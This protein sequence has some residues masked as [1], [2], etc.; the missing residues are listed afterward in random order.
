MEELKVIESLDELTEE[1]K[2]ELSDGRGNTNSVAHLVA[3]LRASAKTAVYASKTYS[4]LASMIVASPFY[5]APRFY[6]ISHIVVHHMSGNL[7]ARLCGR[8]FQNPSA[9]CSSNYGVGSDGT[10]AGYVPEEFR[11]WTTG[12]WQIDHKAITIEVA[13]DCSSPWHCSD[14]AYK[15]TVRL[16]ADICKRNGIKKLTFTGDKNGNLHWHRWYQNTDCPASWWMAKERSGEFTRD[17]ND[18]LNGKAKYTGKLPSKIP[19]RG[20]YRIG[21][22]YETYKGYTGQIKRIQAFLN[23]RGESLAVDG[24][25]GEKTNKAVLRFQKAEGMKGTHGNW[26]KGT[27]EKAEKYC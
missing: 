4:P 26:G 20:Y 15:A 12:N 27:Q 2:L 6:K 11:A 22:G 19:K 21:D 24:F 8:W 13:D 18:I 3:S 7:S 5:T 23:W 9:R 1:Q 14:K 17:V 16:V 25:Y 10:I